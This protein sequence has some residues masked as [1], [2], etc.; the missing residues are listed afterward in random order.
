MNRDQWVKKIVLCQVTV[1]LDGN[2]PAF[3]TDTSSIARPK[4]PESFKQ[5]ARLSG[6]AFHARHHHASRTSK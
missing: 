2:R 6:I 5:D 4:V 1:V 3:V